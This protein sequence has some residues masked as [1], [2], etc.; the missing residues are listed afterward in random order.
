MKKPRS[1]AGVDRLRADAGRGALSRTQ[2][3]LF[4]HLGR[5]EL[6]PAARRHRGNAARQLSE[7]AAGRCADLSGDDGAADRQSADADIRH[8][9][10]VRLTQ[11]TTQDAQGKPLVDPLFEDGTGNPIVS[12][13]QTPTPVT[14]IQWSTE[15]AL[16]FPVCISSTFSIDAATDRRSLMS[17]SSSAT[18]CSPTRA[19]TLRRCPLGTVPEP[20]L[21]KPP[22]PAADRCDPSAPVPLPVRFNPVIPDIPVTQAV[23]LPLAGSPVTP[24]IVPLIPEQIRQP[25]GRQ[26]I[27]LADGRR[28]LSHMSWP[29]YFG[30]VAKPNAVNPANFDLSVVYNPPGGAP[31][32]SPPVDLETFTDLSRDDRRTRQCGHA[33]Q[34]HSHVCPGAEHLYAARD[35]A[36][37]VSVPRHHAVE[38]RHDRSGGRERQ[39][40]ISP[41]SQRT[42]RHGRPT[43]ACWRRAIRRSHRSSTCWSSMTRHPAATASACRSSSSSS[44]TSRWQMSRKC[45][46]PTRNW[47][48]EEL[49]RAAKCEPL[50]YDLMH[51]DADEAVPAMTLTGALSNTQPRGRRSPTC[52]PTP[53]PIHISWSR[54]NPTARRIC[55]SAMTPTA[56]GRT[57]AP[58]SP[59]PIASATARQAMWAPR[60]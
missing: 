12:V 16:P 22:D 37:G 34:L 54:S 1:L 59:P 40:P 15:D 24:G 48:R 26:R 39:R 55:A 11:V 14:E 31:V 42:Q 50:G 7:S 47:S 13:S 28:Q 35:G 6:L 43:S 36:D 3:N 21:F 51:F 53:R 17:A 29:Q 4:L 33:D 8:R 32:V 23:P 2:P 38:R 49:R 60:A 27:H 46:L 56:S 10:A 58:S 52:W 45:S 41:L 5:Y 9:C 30:I 18:S 20:S 44:T 25:E 19:V 57:P